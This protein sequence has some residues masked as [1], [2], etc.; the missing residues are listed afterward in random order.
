M[1]EAASATAQFWLAVKEHFF[2]DDLSEFDYGDFLDL[3]Q[4]LGLLREE[5]YD[6]AKHGIMEC[7]PGDVIHVPTDLA[8]EVQAM[9][10][11]ATDTCLARVKTGEPIFTL[12]AQDATAPELVE[13][14]AERVVARYQREGSEISLE[15]DAKIAE[16]R[17]L[18]QQMRAWQYANGSKLPD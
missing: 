14:W 9:G 18:A 4:R 13:E 10:L 2:E 17:S 3:G 15:V 16:A 5:P 1:S 8:L 7:E 11:K 6:E 12:R